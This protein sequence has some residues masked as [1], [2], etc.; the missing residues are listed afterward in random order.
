MVSFVNGGDSRKKQDTQVK[1]GKKD[2]NKDKVNI[3]ES[4]KD[5]KSIKES[6]M[7]FR[8]ILFGGEFNEDTIR[9]VF[10]GSRLQLTDP[11]GKVRSLRRD[12]LE[13]LETKASKNFKT[14]EYDDEAEEKTSKKKSDAGEKPEGLEIP[15]RLDTKA[16]D[17]EEYIDIGK[18]TVSN[19]DQEDFDET[20]RKKDEKEEEVEEEEE[21]EEE[22]KE[23]EE[24]YSDDVKKED[25]EEESKPNSKTDNQDKSEESERDIDVV[26]LDPNEYLRMKSADQGSIS[27]TTEVEQIATEI[28]ILSTTEETTDATIVDHPEEKQ[29]I[30]V[31]KDQDD[32]VVESKQL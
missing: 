20:E 11:D 18:E 27:S 1:G 9:S 10:E 14:R 19:D 25:T 8:D 17:A 2:R 22:E 12:S 28:P 13:D 30:E 26:I 16:S 24:E 23:E 31:L 29:D 5:F 32:T 7:K 4:N 21:E 3:E 15:L 6:L